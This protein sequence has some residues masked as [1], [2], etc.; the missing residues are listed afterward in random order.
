MN[1][2]YEVSSAQLDELV[3]FLRENWPEV[4]ELP[5]GTLEKKE[6]SYWEK[7]HYEGRIFFYRGE[8][9]SIIALISLSQKEAVVTIDLL[10]IKS[11]FKNQDMV[12]TMLSFA[13]RV[14]VNWS[15]EYINLTFSGREELDLLFPKFH[16]RGYSCQC[17]INQKGNV[18]IEKRLNSETR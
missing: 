16:G 12:M 18:L 13:E 1:H 8:D 11:K 5:L 6:R 10:F 9:D 4:S 2:I 15:G 14:A 7:V 3:A 17:P